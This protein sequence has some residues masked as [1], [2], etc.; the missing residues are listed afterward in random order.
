MR[1]VFRYAPLLPALAL[2]ACGNSQ[3][4]NLPAQQVQAMLVSLPNEA[5]AL[6]LAT[7]YPGTS[8][9]VEPGDQKVTW[10]FAR[11][12]TGEYGRDVAE[13]SEVGPDKS[14][15]STH[16]EDG[17]ADPSLSFLEKVA[18][19]AMDARVTEALTL[20]KK[21][22]ARIDASLKRRRRWRKYPGMRSAHSLRHSLWRCSRSPAPRRKVAIRSR[23]ASAWP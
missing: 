6:S 13:I 14:T 19:I 10:H 4:A 17:P 23:S 11:V 22:A 18:E 2:T 16:F 15:V 1:T 5:N 9:Y 7:S 21:M 12:G 8:Y 3:S 20:S